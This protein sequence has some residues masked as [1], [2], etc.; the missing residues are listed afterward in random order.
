MKLCVRLVPFHDLVDHLVERWRENGRAKC[1][2]FARLRHPRCLLADTEHPPLALLAETFRLG[3]PADFSEDSAGH[4]MLG[5]C[6]PAHTSFTL[7]PYHSFLY[8]GTVF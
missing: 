2:L 7:L 4:A 8:S 5:I 1:L 3:S 6:L